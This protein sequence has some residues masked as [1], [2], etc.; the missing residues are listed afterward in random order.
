MPDTG[1]K[2]R[3]RNSE[4]RDAPPGAATSKWEWVIAALGFLLVLGTVGHIAYTA[5]TTDPSVPVVTVDHITTESTKGG[6]VVTFRARNSG[7]STA[8]ALTISGQLL[9]GTRVVE[10]SE[11]VLDYL[12]SNGERQGG[13]IFQ[14]DPARHEVRLEALGYADP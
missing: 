9:D 4:A 7:A 11:V 2:S 1:N 3:S 13:L 6:H 12:P 10:T 5:L 8:A 14:N